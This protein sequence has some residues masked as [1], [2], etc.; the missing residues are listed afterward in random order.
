MK[1]VLQ[2]RGAGARGG[3]AHFRSVLPL[4]RM[5]QRAQDEGQL[6]AAHDAHAQASPPSIRP[7][8][9]TVKTHAPKVEKRLRVVKIIYYY[10]YLW[11]HVHCTATVVQCAKN[12]FITI[13]LQIPICLNHAHYLRLLVLVISTVCTIIHTAFHDCSKACFLCTLPKFTNHEENFV[14]K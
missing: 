11:K 1:V 14:Y 2:W 10:R 3:H 5:R 7:T 4:R 9:R 13:F 6:E 12:L 8:T